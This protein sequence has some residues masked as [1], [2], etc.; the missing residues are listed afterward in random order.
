[1]SGHAVSYT[2]FWVPFIE[3]VGSATT[4][5]ISV[6]HRNSGIRSGKRKTN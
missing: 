2:C 6:W 3:S 5:F 1:L 4:H